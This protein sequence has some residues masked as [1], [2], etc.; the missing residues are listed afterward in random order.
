MELT[1][2]QRER[3]IERERAV[4]EGDNDALVNRL[5]IGDLGAKRSFYHKHCSINIRFINKQKEDCKGKNDNDHV[6]PAAQEKWLHL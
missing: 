2:N 4:Y 5:R 3:E 1:N 6:K